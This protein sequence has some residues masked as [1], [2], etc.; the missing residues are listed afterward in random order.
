MAALG[1]S[2]RT[3]CCCHRCCETLLTI[4]QSLIC[5]FSLSV[6]RKNQ[7]MP[8]K[9]CVSFCG[10]ISYNG[11]GHVSKTLCKLLLV[12]S[13]T[14]G[15]AWWQGADGP[16]QSIKKLSST[17]MAGGHD[18][19]VPSKNKRAQRPAGPL[20]QAREARER[21]SGKIRTKICREQEVRWCDTQSEKS[22]LRT[23]LVRQ[24]NGARLYAALLLKNGSMGTYRSASRLI[25]MEST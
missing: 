17:P 6:F 21:S 23:H 12:Q 24:A 10:T 4:F 3:G 11:S 9:R 15:I 20:P 5:H 2:R 1:H 22:V 8:P 14:M 25:S 18:Q 16:L 7:A 19:M 13:D